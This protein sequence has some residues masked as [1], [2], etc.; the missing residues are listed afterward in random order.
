MIFNAEAIRRSETL[1]ANIVDCIFFGP[2]L[3]K[4]SEIFKATMSSV[5]SIVI[6]LTEDSIFSGSIEERIKSETERMPM[7]IAIDLTSSIFTLEEKPLMVS[8][9]SPN[10]DFIPFKKPPASFV[11]PVKLFI[12]FASSNPNVAKTPFLTSFSKLKS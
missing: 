8:T 12:S 9:S 3:L 6:A 1:N 11:T 5:N 10:I 2:E 4:P 7:L